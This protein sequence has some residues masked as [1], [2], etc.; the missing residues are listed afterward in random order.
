M[1]DEY[2]NV[3][4]LVRNCAQAYLS[5][6]VGIEVVAVAVKELLEVFKEQGLVITGVNLDEL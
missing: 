2:T 4:R 3:V 5:S 6:M 1:D